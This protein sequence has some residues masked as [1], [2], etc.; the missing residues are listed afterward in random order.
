MARTLRVG[1]NNEVYADPDGGDPEQRLDGALTQAVLTTEE[2]DNLI[3][4]S[5]SAASLAMRQRSTTYLCEDG[6][7]TTYVNG[8][9]WSDQ[10]GGGGYPGMSKTLTQ[11]VVG[12]TLQEN[13][14]FGSGAVAVGA[15]QNYSVTNAASLAA[16]M[17]PL[18]GN[19]YGGTGAA[20][21]NAEIQRYALDF[22]SDTHVFETDAVTLQARLDAGT[23]NVVLVGQVNTASSG[24]WI[25]EP[26]AS[27]TTPIANL[28]LVVGDL[29]TIQV[30]QV[31]SIVAGFG[32][33]FVA[34]INVGAQT[35]TLE[36]LTCG[37]AAGLKT[38]GAV[39]FWPC[40]YAKVSAAVADGVDTVL[41][42]TAV[43][44]GV[45]AGMYTFGEL[46]PGSTLLAYDRSKVL[47]KTS[48]TVTLDAPIGTGRALNPAVNSGVLFVPGV[49]CG[50]MWSKSSYDFKGGGKKAWAFE[51]EITMPSQTSAKGS[52]HSTAYTKT[53]Q[54]AARASYPNV[55]WGYW[56]ALWMFYCKPNGTQ[57]GYR[58]MYTELDILEV[59]CRFGRGPNTWTGFSHDQPYTRKKSNRLAGSWQT[60]TADSKLLTADAASFDFNNP[61]CDGLKHK[62]GMYWTETKV[63]R[64]VDGLPIAEDDWAMESDYPMQLGLNVACGSLHG[65]FP[66]IPQLPV[67]DS[68]VTGQFMKIHS[69]KTWCM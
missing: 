47:S 53:A 55:L 49:R 14:A 51:I 57:A 21:I 6:R 8:M 60:S 59:F 22:T 67:A 1:V 3:G 17:N 56:P 31:G 36:R 43:P 63:I 29:S 50:Q 54:D 35:I 64:Y 41:N 13:Y 69:I 61:I 44:G 18:E 42:F 2:F 37:A 33:F 7:K 10:A 30:G 38:N 16:C 66:N 34:E 23:W 65:G 58:E 19:Q 40:Y 32:L 45:V 4:G 11:A 25:N 15:A 39:Y 28:G 68:Q 12:L 24:F 62:I 5:P 46:S 27:L 52:L 48:T 20:S 9:A 26:G